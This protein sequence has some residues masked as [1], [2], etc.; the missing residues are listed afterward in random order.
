MKN[1]IAASLLMFCLAGVAS[2]QT[3]D[4]PPQ[5][6]KQTRKSRSEAK[7]RAQQADQAM[8]DAAQTSPAMATAK[9]ARAANDADGQAQVQ[10]NDQAKKPEDDST[11]NVVEYGG[12]GL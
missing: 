12:G 2:A 1:R 7:K 9:A 11:Q 3:T 4:A 8:A 6:T 10:V 5:Q